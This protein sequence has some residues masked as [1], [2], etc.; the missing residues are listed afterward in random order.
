[1][2]GTAISSNDGLGALKRPANVIDS[3]VL[4]TIIS[5]IDHRLIDRSIRSLP[6][7]NRPYDNWQEI[8]VDTRGLKF[9]TVMSALSSNNPRWGIFTIELELE[10]QRS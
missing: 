4:W 8:W 9:D 3:L 6:L 10:R 1:V 2:P 7:F 5:L